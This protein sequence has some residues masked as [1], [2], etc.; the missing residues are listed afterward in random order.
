M[1]ETIKGSEW[2]AS[3]EAPEV[4]GD[5]IR[6]L[7]V[8]GRE[9]KNAWNASTDSPGDSKGPRRKFN[10]LLSAQ[11]ELAKFADKP[12]YLLHRPSP[13]DEAD[14][15]GVFSKPRSTDKGLRMDLQLLHVNGAEG[16]THLHPQ[17]A[18]L[19]DN[20]Q[21]KRPFGGF[22]P[23]FDF[24]IDPTTGEVH[25]IVA[26]ESIDLVPMPASVRSALEEETVDPPIPPDSV[27]ALEARIAALEARSIPAVESHVK[28]VPPPA[29]APP[30]TVTGNFRDFIRG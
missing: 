13:R 21:H 26:V 16:S 2:C 17:G 28:N 12:A 27:K 5:F 7:L 10:V 1:L 6:G 24:Q 30:A 25:T 19:I 29:P 3:E 18:A 14:Q 15:I 22:S 23:R 8:L 11:E 20:I 9:S 4:Q